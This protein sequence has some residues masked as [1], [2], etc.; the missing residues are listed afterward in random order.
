MRPALHTA[1]LPAVLP[2]VASNLVPIAGVLALGWSPAAVLLVYQAELAAICVWT[3]LK[4]PF[5]RKR[6]NNDVSSQSYLFGPLQQKRGAIS[7]PGPLPP[8]YPRNVPTLLV[9]IVL[10][11]PIVGYAFVPFALMR[12]EITDSV[13]AALLLGAG[14]VFLI[15]GIDTWC[16]YFYG[17]KYREHSPRSLL[18]TPFKYL[19]VVGSLFVVFT[20]V[21]SVI[22]TNAILRTER[23]VLLLAVGKLGYDVRTHRLKH[24]DDRR[25]V[26][27]KLYG[28]QETEIDPE[29]VKVP[30]CPPVRRVSMSRR[31]ALLDALSHGIWFGFGAVGIF[32]WVIIGLGLLARSTTVVLF[33][34][35][36][37]GF[38]AALRTGARY[39]RYGTLEYHCYEDVLVA[40][41]KLLNEPQAKMEDHAVTDAVVSTGRLDR[42]FGTETLSFEVMSEDSDPDM[43]LFV[44]NPEDIDTKDDANESA[45][46]MLLH[47]DA[48]REVTDTLDLSRYLDSA[49]S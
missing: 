15:R 19:F 31:V 12:P 35:V 45:P 11:P 8:V 34:L 47:L 39:L 24:D 10:T 13:A 25:G 38:L 23:A 41:D 43:R 28:S 30:D 32:T 27:A 40:Y 37:G 49:S 20:G 33:G 48:S 22:E 17:E 6:P 36:V 26:F 46:L 4:I 42:L 9:A 16:E 18:L 21:E 44:P 5:A 1:A 7:V 2:I 29:L 14:V 3:V